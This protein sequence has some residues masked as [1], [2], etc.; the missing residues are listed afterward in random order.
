MLLFVDPSKKE[1]IG[2]SGCNVKKRISVSRQ[3]IRHQ[4]Y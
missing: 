1:Q 4:R 2:K 3:H